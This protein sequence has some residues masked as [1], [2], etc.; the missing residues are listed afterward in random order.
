[1]MVRSA[2]VWAP[3]GEV[4]SATRASNHAVRMV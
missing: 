4:S 3:P 2:G 1:V